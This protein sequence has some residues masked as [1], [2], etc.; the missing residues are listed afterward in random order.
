MFGA[1]V[2]FFNQW[3]PSAFEG[4]VNKSWLVYHSAQCIVQSEGMHRLNDLR[5]AIHERTFRNPKLNQKDW[6]GSSQALLRCG[7]SGQAATYECVHKNPI[8]IL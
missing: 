3:L 4:Q 2:A 7:S 6:A 8:H 5:K 1:R